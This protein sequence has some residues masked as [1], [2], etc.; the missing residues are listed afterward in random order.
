VDNPFAKARNARFGADYSLTED[1]L[2]LSDLVGNAFDGKIRGEV[3]V[4]NWN[5]SSTL[6]RNGRRTS[7][8]AQ[9]GIAR[10]RVE[11]V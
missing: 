2:S 3:E 10:L 9:R 4:V 5:N 7:E 1:R 6:N 11:Q 8:A